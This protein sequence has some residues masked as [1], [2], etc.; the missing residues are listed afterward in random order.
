MIA[1][2][3][4]FLDL[5]S[6]R[7]KVQLWILAAAMVVLAVVETA[8]VASIL[9][10]IAV[11]NNPEVIQRN[12]WLRLA[13]DSL[14]YASPQSFLVSLGIV[15]L[16]FIVFSNVVKALTAWWRLSY[17]N[18]LNYTLAR[19]LLAQYMAR[20]YAFFL[21]RNTSDMTK[22]IL[23]EVRN[24]IG[25]V[26][27]AGMEI[28]SSSLVCLF[29]LGLLLAIDPFI[30]IVIM[31]VLSGAYAGIYFLARRK[32]ARIGREQ[33]VASS[34]KYRAANEALGAIKD[35]KILGRERSFLERFSDHARRH[36]LNNVSGGVISALPRY[37][38][39]ILAFGG[40]LALM[41]HFLRIQERSGHVIPLLALYAF[42][43]YRLLPAVQQIFS[44]ITS[45]RIN[46]YSLRV[47]HQDLVQ[48]QTGAGAEA[49]L[50]D[51]TEA[52]PV[53]FVQRLELRDISFSYPEARDPVLDAFNLTVVPHS[54][55]GLVGATGSGKTTVVDLILG[56][57]TPGSGRIFVDGVDI[58]EC[59]SRWQRNLGYVPQHIFLSD[60]TVLANIAFG[61]P[62]GEIDMAAVKRAAS[63]A[64]LHS[65]IEE[66][67][68]SGYHTAVG[69][70]GIRLSGG[71]RQRLGIARA[72][73]RDPPILIMD[74]ATSALDG[75]TEEAVTEAIR[76]LS[77]RKTLITIA[78]RLTT[79]KDCDVIYLMDQGRIAGRGTYAELMKTSSWFRAAARTG[80]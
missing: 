62:E 6:P 43:G 29:M 14:G 31:G 35:L 57:L 7:E 68:P 39:E 49:A 30:A 46:L 13:Y 60:D 10:F 42:A 25:G 26:L 4:Q 51:F 38:L 44:A 27:S 59:L 33:V 20:P 73:Y 71:Q 15:V 32:L 41:L 18:N 24:C 37:V 40:I 61:V 56:L 12:P 5:L 34:M 19:R 66:E 70:R 45:V 69:E 80:A 72:L 58:Q 23:T 78:H 47:L 3:K 28:L 21:N 2:A 17:D 64:N 79:V 8:G 48:G 55:V 22:N 76:A 11:V 75:I 65:F 77:G 1:T 36:A 50:P 63:V 16:A 9:P 52:K 74:E 54:S 67:L 53:P